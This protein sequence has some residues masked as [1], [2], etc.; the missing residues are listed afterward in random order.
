VRALACSL[1]LADKK[2]LGRFVDDMKQPA[3]AS[4]RTTS[5]SR[6]AGAGASVGNVTRAQYNQVLFSLRR[7]RETVVA[8]ARIGALGTGG[9]AG[10]GD[11]DGG[12][13]GGGDSDDDDDDDDDDDNRGDNIK[14]NPNLRVVSV[15]LERDAATELAVHGTIHS[16]VD[17]CT[18]AVQHRRVAADQLARRAGAFLPSCTCRKWTCVGGWQKRYEQMKHAFNTLEGVGDQFAIPRD[19]WIDAHTVVV[20]LYWLMECVG[21]STNV[22]RAV[23]CVFLDE[24]HQQ[25]SAMCRTLGQRLDD[26]VSDADVTSA[27]RNAARHL[28]AVIPRGMYVDAPTTATLQSLAD[29]VRNAAAHVNPLSEEWVHQRSLKLPARSSNDAFVPVFHSPFVGHRRLAGQ[30]EALLQENDDGS[31][32]LRDGIR[33]GSTA[34][35]QWLT[36]HVFNRLRDRGGQ[37]TTRNVLL[38]GPPG[39]GKTFSA[40]ACAENLGLTYIIVKVSDIESKWSGQA[41][42]NIAACWDAMFVKQ[43]VVMILDECERL[44]AKRQ[45]GE[46][47]DGGDGGGGGG[48][49][50]SEVLS[51]LD[52][53]MGEV[54]GLFVVGI[55]NVY[56]NLDAAVLSRF[57]TKRRVADLSDADKCIIIRNWIDKYKFVE[58]H[59]VT[60][61]VL[62]LLASRCGPDLRA[63]EEQVFAQARNLVIDAAL[64]VP[65]G[66][67]RR[68]VIATLGDVMRDDC[69]LWH[70]MHQFHAGM[71]REAAVARAQQW[72]LPLAFPFAS[73]PQHAAQQHVPSPLR[74]KPLMTLRLDRSARRYVVRYRRLSDPQEQYTSFSFRSLE[75][76][77]GAFV[78]ARALYDRLLREFNA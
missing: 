17:E 71:T 70:C 73:A 51:Y 16:T 21:T 33:A 27:L 7:A 4:P 47:G 11:G 28:C 25:L 10:D 75:T 44:F 26:V 58:S 67:A 62:E 78:D 65:A 66:R 3:A 14:Y 40:K 1:P 48:D 49:L 69:P 41:G 74:A 61:Q 24:Q 64:R 46:S 43:P 34:A 13:G 63:F 38:Y 52:G 42:K 35:E 19:N 54:P 30:N 6:R 60:T 31:L 9:G 29:A 37:Q 59:L 45:S 20:F 32:R 55:T 8:F 72:Q 39:T 50:V 36:R 68:S 53:T 76:A 23:V 12:G 77:Q 15:R 2:V 5:T 22:G 57:P 18:I 56:E